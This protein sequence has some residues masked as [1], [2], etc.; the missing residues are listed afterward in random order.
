MSL[1]GGEKVEILLNG[2]KETISENTTLLNFLTS[3]G[4]NPDTIVVEYNL[5]VLK[6]E[7]WS[8]T[9][10]KENDNLEVLSFVGGG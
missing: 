2:Q 8:N 1:A 9:I 5:N 6:N 4:L 10:L 3:N 7:E